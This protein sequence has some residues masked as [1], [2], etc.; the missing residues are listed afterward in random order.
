MPKSDTDVIVV[1]AGPTGLTLATELRLHG[2]RAL[3]LD[4]LLH[5]REEGKAGGFGGRICTLLR[6]RGEWERC[7]AASGQPQP[8]PRFP[9]GG[10][11]VDLTQLADPPMEA[12]VLPQPRMEAG[13]VERAGGLGADV[14]RGHEVIGLEQDDDGV[15][16]DVRGPDG[17]YR[18][19]ARYVVGC[20]GVRSPVRR[21]AGIAFP[22]VTYPEVN[23]LGSFAMPDS[24]T[25]RD[26]GGF[27][28]PGLGVLPFGYTQT[29]RGVFAIS[30]YGPDTGAFGVYTAE[31]ED[32]TFDDDEP[33]TVDEFAASIRRVLGGDVPLGE[34]RRL[35]RFTYHARHVETYR[36]GTVF[37]AGDAAHQFPSGGVAVTAGMLDVVNLAWKLAGAIAGWAPDG[38]LDTY[39][40]ERHYAGARTLLHT[41]A[42]LA[43]RRGLDEPA[44]ALRAVF[45]ELLAD[46]SA[47]RRV[48]AMIAGADISYPMP[49]AHP[50]A[51]VFAPE[52][53]VDGRRVCDVVQTARPLLLDFAGGLDVAGWDD[54][55]DVRVEPAV[56][57][58]AD[59]LLIRPDGHVA[60]AGD[61]AADGLPEA[62]AHWF[63]PPT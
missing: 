25:R 54:R 51:G 17:E 28:V 48:G 61:G 43:L 57:R 34:P 46:E 53:E 4:R 30:S 13:F 47:A 55:V 60:W 36:A 39:H 37:V 62:L 26:D 23:R 19:T 24:I 11:H 29:E 2:A 8:A 22:G 59:A 27:D 41:Q 20:D 31:D 14:R 50:L 18:L 7:T 63:G 6:F 38:L 5:P 9:F 42:Q 58:P 15:A 32:R 16:V 56:R 44:N 40:A 52:L 21:M 49:D 12:L 33:L 10:L 3:V 45:A 35:T 1:G